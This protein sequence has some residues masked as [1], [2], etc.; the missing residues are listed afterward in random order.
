MTAMNT[1]DIETTQH[2]LRRSAPS[3][4]DLHHF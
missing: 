2:K 4:I 1:H 3:F